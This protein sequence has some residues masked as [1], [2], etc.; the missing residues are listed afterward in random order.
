MMTHTPGPWSW[1]TSN[2]WKRLRRDDHGIAQTVLEP[3]VSL[4]GYPDCTV[5]PADM[6]LI[7]AA[8]DLLA[9]LRNAEEVIANLIG[10]YGDGGAG[11]VLAEARAAIRKATS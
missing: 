7:S 10:M 2:S 11:L 6:A 9:A 8:P 4:D 3:Y 5:S 1:W